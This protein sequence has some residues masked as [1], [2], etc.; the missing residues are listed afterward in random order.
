MGISAAFDTVSA[1]GAVAVLG[2]VSALVIAAA[3]GAGLA[4]LCFFDLAFFA[5]VLLASAVLAGIAA[6]LAA[7]APPVAADGGVGVT[8]GAVAGAGAA[9]AVGVVVC[10]TAVSEMAR[11]LALSAVNSLFMSCP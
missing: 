8:D 5:A 6:D 10:A 7:G 1:L 3:F 11:A 4:S 9:G 2:A